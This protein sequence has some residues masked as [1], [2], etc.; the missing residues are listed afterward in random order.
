[1][2]CFHMGNVPCLCASIICYSFILITSF[3]R[4]VQYD[5]KEDCGCMLLGLLK[6]LE[7][8]VS[9]LFKVINRPS[10]ARTKAYLNK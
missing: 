3:G 5:Y 10:S 7:A 1:M 2:Q 4:N 6:R 9:S 8:Q